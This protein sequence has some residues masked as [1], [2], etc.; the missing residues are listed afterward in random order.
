MTV[1][2]RY[3]QDSRPR[4]SSGWVLTPGFVYLVGNRAHG[5]YKIGRTQDIAARMATLAKGVPFEFDVCEYFPC[6]DS[7]G[8]ES[9]VHAQLAEWR[10]K[11]EW[12]QMTPAQADQALK[13]MFAS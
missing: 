10:V 5:Y 6:K 11:K 9:R 4:G 1:L 2:D 7:R 13:L 8:R 12:Y 3:E